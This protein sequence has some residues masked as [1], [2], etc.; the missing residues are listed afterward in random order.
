MAEALDSATEAVLPGTPGIREIRSDTTTVQENFAGA[1]T[2]GIR[3]F[4]LRAEIDTSPPFGS[5]KEAVTRFGG[6]GPWLP[7]GKL[8]ETYVSTKLLTTKWI[9][10]FICQKKKSGYYFS[11]VDIF[12]LSFG[13]II[14]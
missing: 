14:V 1:P 4:G 11:L 3:R 2:S 10:F 7:F 6:S 13:H 12:F 8:G 5:V 9:L